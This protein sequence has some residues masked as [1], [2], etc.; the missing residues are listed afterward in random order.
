MSEPHLPAWRP[1][2]R[3]RLTFLAACFALWA[4]AV[5]VRLLYLQVLQY[6]EMV[7][8]AASF[9]GAPM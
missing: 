2:V 7:K 8:K 5:V 3:R 4:G 1:T 9:T 6:D